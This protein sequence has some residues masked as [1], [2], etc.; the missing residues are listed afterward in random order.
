MMGWVHGTHALLLAYSMVQVPMFV[1]LARARAPFREFVG[2]PLVA[3]PMMLIAALGATAS[4]AVMPHSGLLVGMG[5]SVALGYAGGR[6]AARSE[7]ESRVYQRGTLVAQ[8]VRPCRPRSASAGR[9]RDITLA[10]LSV[11]QLDETKHFK[12]IGTTGTGKSTAIGEMLSRA[13]ARGDRAV[14]ADPDGGYMARFYD[15]DRGDVVL[16]PFDSQSVKWDLFA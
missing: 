3:A 7:D 14:I 9:G 15:R 13:L 5:L 8:S 10:G 16:N 4:E 6:T 12:L 2:S 11:P 1:G